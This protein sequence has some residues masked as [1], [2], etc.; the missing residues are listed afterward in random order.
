MDEYRQFEETL[1]CQTYK[2]LLQ[3][4]GFR[5]L[6]MTGMRIG[7]MLALNWEQVDFKGQMI[8]IEKT[9][10]YRSKTKNQLLSPKT[11]ASQRTIGIDS[12]TL[13]LL[14]EWQDKQKSIGNIDYVFQIDGSFMNDC[15]W[16]YWLKNLAIQADVPPIKLHS[17]RHSHASMLIS[18]GESS[19]AS[20]K[21][22]E[23]LSLLE[24]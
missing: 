20:Q 18:I 5:L 3:K 1:A 16:R 11:K 6:F 23:K 7:E 12:K 2:E 19:L 8:T 21:L 17:L 10:Y 24:I 4:T 9:L 14:S 22:T 15:V 13:T